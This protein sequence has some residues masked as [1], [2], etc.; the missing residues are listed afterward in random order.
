M[1]SCWWFTLHPNA[2]QTQF[3]RKI[4]IF[5]VLLRPSVPS[6]TTRGQQKSPESRQEVRTSRRTPAAPSE[7][8]VSAAAEGGRLN[9]ADKKL[10]IEGIMGNDMRHSGVLK[11]E[12]L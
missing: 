4:L 1:T 7:T 10:Q 6:A 9:I 12:S 5:G 2:P 8:K 11:S 3:S